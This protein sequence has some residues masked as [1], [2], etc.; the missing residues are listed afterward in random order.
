MLNQPNI[1]LIYTGG[2]IG[3]IQDEES[4]IY[5]P[6]SIEHLLT[7]VPRLSQLKVNLSTVSFTTP[8]DSAHVGPQEW[9]TIKDRIAEGYE[10]YDGFVVL[11]GTDTMAF[12]ASALGFLLKG[13]NKPVVFTG[14][15]L[16][17]ST[18]RSD[19][20]ENLITAIEIASAQK[21]GQ[22]RVPEVTVLFD[23]TLHRGARSS[24]INAE[25][26]NAFASPNCAPLATAGVHIQYNDELIGV[27]V[28]TP[29]FLDAINTN[30]AVIDLYP[31][32]DERYFTS[33]VDAKWVKG[34]VLKTFGTGTVNFTI[35][36]IDSLR[37]AQERGVV[38]LA[39][40]QCSVGAIE[41][42]KYEASSVLADL[43]VVSGTDL[44]LEAA[45]TKM[46]VVLGNY[47]SQEEV[48]KQLEKN[49]IGEKS[50]G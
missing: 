33:I 25:N 21:N 34:I 7:F 27:P 20:Q 49:W 43:K 4:G 35:S 6:F 18:V 39:I 42:G 37:K 36:C 11:H 29:E 41:I 22:P 31:G 24:K 40:S 32:M 1:L 2:T 30:V 46:M 28:G 17:I 47:T 38:I 10:K 19:A 13:L 48:S 26:F 5:L 8:L 15:Q 45:L 12:S 50:I 23:S 16:P 9:L 44:T 3:M 14:S